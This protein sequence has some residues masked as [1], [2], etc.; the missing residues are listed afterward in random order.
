MLYEFGFDFNTFFG[1]THFLTGL[2]FF[3]FT[4]NG[5]GI[6]VDVFEFFML[7]LLLLILV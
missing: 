6:L 7:L 1:I 3:M 2:F 5:F 4:K